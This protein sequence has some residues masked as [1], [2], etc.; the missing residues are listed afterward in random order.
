M[1]TA[2]TLTRKA[3]DVATQALPKHVHML[4]ASM[5]W[6]WKTLARSFRANEKNVHHQGCCKSSCSP[7]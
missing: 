5:A 7:V 4:L 3:N 1:F 6:L 2:I